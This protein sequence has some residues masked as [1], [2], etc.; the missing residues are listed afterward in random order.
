LKNDSERRN[1]KDLL[2]GRGGLMKG[3]EMEVGKYFHMQPFDAT[4]THTDHIS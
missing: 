2:E 4:I 1:E 3:R